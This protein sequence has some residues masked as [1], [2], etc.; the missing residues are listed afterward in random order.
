M[1]LE[2][3]LIHL[4][5]IAFLFLFAA[6]SA[7]VLKTEAEENRLSSLSG[8]NLGSEVRRGVGTDNAV[9]FTTQIMDS[10]SAQ[11]NMLN[12]ADYTVGQCQQDFKFY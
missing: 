5:L 8:D 9:A 11:P 2:S 10:A 7:L 6:S 3:G 4:I 12:N 1:I